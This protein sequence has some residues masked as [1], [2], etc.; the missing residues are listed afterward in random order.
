MEE[1]EFSRGGHV[2][3]ETH[4]DSM[5]SPKAKASSQTVLTSYINTTPRRKCGP[6][7]TSFQNTTENSPRRNSG[8]GHNYYAQLEDGQTNSELDGSAFLSSDSTY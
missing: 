3:T 2:H 7:V 5:L 8:D 4:N 1:K 6:T